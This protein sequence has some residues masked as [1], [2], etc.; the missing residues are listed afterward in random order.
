MLERKKW[1]NETPNMQVGDLVLVAKTDSPRGNWPLGRVVRCIAGDAG[2]VRAVE[3][4]TKTGNLVR[5]VSKV[6]LLEE[7]G[8]QP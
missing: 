6:A 2:V 8:A 7:V 3:V 4:K 5:P 1:T